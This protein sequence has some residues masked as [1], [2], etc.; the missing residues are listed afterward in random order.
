MHLRSGEIFNDCFVTNER[1]NLP[2][3]EFGNG[4]WS[5]LGKVMDKSITSFFVSTHT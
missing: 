2:V 3:K 5:M 4:H 1:L